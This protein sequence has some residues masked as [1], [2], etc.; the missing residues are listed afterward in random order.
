MMVADFL[1]VMRQSFG[2]D[3]FDLQVNFLL[4]AVN[5]DGDAY[6]LIKDWVCRDHSC[7]KETYKGD[8]IYL[9]GQDKT[10]D[11]YNDVLPRYERSQVTCFNKLALLA[12]K[13][14][15]INAMQAKAETVDYFAEELE[16]TPEKS[17]TKKIAQSWP[18]MDCIQT[19]VL[20]YKKS[21][22]ENVLKQ[23]EEHLQT[24]LKAI[25]NTQVLQDLLQP[26]VR[27][28][29]SQYDDGIKCGFRLF[30]QIPGAL[31]KIKQFLSQEM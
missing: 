21:K 27:T 12:I 16:K 18:V 23:Q 10:E 11:F 31:V 8:W 25:T 30:K 14:K 20:G 22:Y 6:N 29:N 3:P 5:R 9:T 19:F 15:T 26:D 28:V 17:Q 1:E 2:M 13:M 7:F 24:Y 4:I